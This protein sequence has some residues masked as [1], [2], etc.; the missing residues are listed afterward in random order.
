MLKRINNIIQE[1]TLKYVNEV[2]EMKKETTEVAQ[3][4][5]LRTLAGLAR[6]AH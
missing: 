4:S 5:Y 1:G 3:I 2:W 6:A